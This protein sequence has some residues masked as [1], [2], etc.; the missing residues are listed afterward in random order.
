MTDRAFVLENRSRVVS[1]LDLASK[2]NEHKPVTCYEAPAEILHF[3]GVYRDSKREM[4]RFCIVDRSSSALKLLHIEEKNLTLQCELR[5][6]ENLRK[7]VSDDM[8]YANGLI[9]KRNRF[10]DMQSTGAQAGEKSEYFPFRDKYLHGEVDYPKAA[11]KRLLYVILKKDE[12][13]VNC[14]PMLNINEV[15]NTRKDSR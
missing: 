9:Y 5:V 6:M 13:H 11:S 7:I 10:Y 1:L 4:M 15:K 2:S 3:S 12:H 14:L 8:F